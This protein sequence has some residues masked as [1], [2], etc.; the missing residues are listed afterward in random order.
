VAD[1]YISLSYDQYKSLE[2]QAVHFKE[3]ESVHE[4]VDRRFYHKALRLDLGDGLV[5]EFQGPRV[6]AP[7]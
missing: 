6:M 7:Q 3:N 2:E 4:T 5:F 1:I